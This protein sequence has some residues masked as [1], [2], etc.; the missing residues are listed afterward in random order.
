M[1]DYNDLRSTK[2]MTTKEILIEANACEDCDP[3][4]IRFYKHWYIKHEY[5]CLICTEKVTRKK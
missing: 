4:G 3:A 1:L 5:R 2:S